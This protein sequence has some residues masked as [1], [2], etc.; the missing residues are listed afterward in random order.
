MRPVVHG[1]HQAVHGHGVQPLV[2]VLHLPYPPQTV[3]GSVVKLE[4]QVAG[5]RGGVAAGIDSVDV[6]AGDVD[7]FMLVGFFSG[8]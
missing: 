4:D 5:G 2:G 6:V 7:L 8:T 1:N 3:Q